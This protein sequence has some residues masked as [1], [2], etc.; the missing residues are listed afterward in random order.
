MRYSS[1]A[2]VNWILTLLILL[3]AA[4]SMATQSTGQPQAAEQ[5]SPAH[6]LLISLHISSFTV[7]SSLHPPPSLHLI[8]IPWSHLS[9]LC[10]VGGIL[11]LKQNLKTDNKE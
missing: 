5:S 9:K 7:S 6:L 2:V 8:L 10:I 4:V 3:L 11:S 1:L